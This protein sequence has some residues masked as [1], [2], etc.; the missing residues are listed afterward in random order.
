MLPGETTAHVG[1]AGQDG[2][3]LVGK[4]SAKDRAQ[5]NTA[6]IQ[7]A[8]LWFIQVVCDIWSNREQ[9]LGRFFGASD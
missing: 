1:P 9:L 4:A 3:A 5:P 2:G 8:H 6:R 7:E